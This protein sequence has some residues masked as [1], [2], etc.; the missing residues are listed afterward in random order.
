VKAGVFPLEDDELLTES[1]DL[2]P[3]PVS[4]K[5]VRAEVSD[6][7]DDEACHDVILIR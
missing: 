7:A 5:D 2:Q 1:G 3:E 6:C 4:R